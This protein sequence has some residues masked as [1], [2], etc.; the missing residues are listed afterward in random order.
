M[1]L[2]LKFR[3]LLT[4]HTR[5]KKCKWVNQISRMQHAQYGKSA[6]GGREQFHIS[7]VERDAQKIVV[8][9]FPVEV[10]FSANRGKKILEW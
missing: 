3:N 10:I 6:R 9:S 5:N 7:L 8:N 4:N 1:L 2:M